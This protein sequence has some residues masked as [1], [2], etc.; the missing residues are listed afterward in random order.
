M[1]KKVLFVI[2]ALTVGGAE[3][4]LIKLLNYIK[5]DYNIDL[6][7]LTKNGVLINEVPKEV[8]L[9]YLYDPKVEWA[10]NPVL[11]LVRYCR[12]FLH[13]IM[14][15]TLRYSDLYY[16]LQRELK[17]KNKYDVEIA[18]LEPHPFQFIAT[19]KKGTKTI[20]SV[21]NSLI[22][23]ERDVA[24]KWYLKVVEE[25]FNRVDRVFCVS[26]DATNEFKEL[27]PQ[28]ID[29]VCTIDNF[30]EFDEV[31]R[32]AKEKIDYK[33]DKKMI[34]VI[35]VGRCSYQK[36]YMRLLKA[37]KK[38][39]NSG[40]KYCLHI[41]GRYSY[42]NGKFYGEGKEMLKYIEDNNLHNS[43]IL[44]GEVANPFPYVKEADVYISSAY[45]EG[46]PRAITEALIL[47]K[48][49]VAT[50]VS[51]T[52]YVLGYGKYG[53]LVEDN[54]LGLFNGL[55]TIVGDKVK[56]EKYSKCSSQFKDRKDEIITEL[57]K[58]IEE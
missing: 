32:K 25:S 22:N 34:N 41:L 9:I 1:K 19:A 17:I 29:K 39:I 15:F 31:R 2:S 21:R 46:Y 37:H 55:K 47:G 56:R 58:M 5:G 35:T 45:Y 43:V 30:F 3:N 48:P 12:D 44:H 8:N 51:G 26:E 11:N 28:N 54:E 10:E 16:R 49:V 7:L 53:L 40:Y 20:C 33:F 36:G 23:P 50:N 42:E 4:S 38:L 57:K 27:Y 18:Y 24:P 52:A 13:K 6:L 14:A